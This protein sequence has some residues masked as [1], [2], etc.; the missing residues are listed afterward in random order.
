MSTTPSRLLPFAVALLAACAGV[1]PAG[2]PADDYV[3]CPVV[4]PDAPEGS[5][6]ELET[7]SFT[8]CVPGHWRNVGRRR[9]AGDGGYVEWDSGDLRRRE[10]GPEIFRPDRY[11]PTVTYLDRRNV[12]IGGGTGDIWM[13]ETQGDYR[14][15]A[16]W[17]EPAGVYM[18][19]RSRSEATARLQLRVYA[20]VRFEEGS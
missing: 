3:P 4:V 14:T 2:E 8:F 13:T 6:R 17:R 12:R 11:E 10:R 7:P 1:P 9:V 18:T 15:G 19:G 16:Q 5:W 20:T